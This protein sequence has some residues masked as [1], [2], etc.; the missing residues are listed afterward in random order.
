[1]NI[2]ALHGE[3][4]ADGKLG[5][6][7]PGDTLRLAHAL[8][9]PFFERNKRNISLVSTFDQSHLEGLFCCDRFERIP[10]TDCQV[11]GTVSVDFI[12]RLLSDIFREESNKSCIV[13]AFIGKEEN[14]PF[15]GILETIDHSKKIARQR[16]DSTNPS[17]SYMFHDRWDTPRFLNS[18]MNSKNSCV[19]VF[20]RNILTA[21]NLNSPPGFIDI[22]REILH[23]KGLSIIW[24]GDHDIIECQGNE[25][26]IRAKRA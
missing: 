20:I 10:A 25:K 13:H 26:K 14:Y 11:A 22:V 16:I 17:T 3:F 7:G 2:I 1:M 12:F 5:H 21:K 18:E 8:R 15:K 19:A 4:K 23:E 6:S 9:H 24:C